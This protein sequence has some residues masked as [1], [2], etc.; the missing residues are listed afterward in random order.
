[1]PSQPTQA[2][3]QLAVMPRHSIR[4]FTH[5]AL[6]AAIG[7]QLSAFIGVN[8]LTPRVARQPETKIT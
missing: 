6:S 2:F 3:T 7:G 5:I 8:R 4:S 1:V